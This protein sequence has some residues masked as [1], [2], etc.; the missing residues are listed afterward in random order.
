MFDVCISMMYVC[1]IRVTTTTVKIQNV[2]FTSVM[3]PFSTFQSW[4]NAPTPA[5]NYWFLSPQFTS[6]LVLECHSNSRYMVYPF[7]FLRSIST[8]PFWDSLMLLG[9]SLVPFYHQAEFQW[10]NVYHKLF[11]YWWTF[12]FFPLWSYYKY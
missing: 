12:G 4:L 9:I 2:F 8:S 7:L 11:F 6:L 10:M 3:F 1:I 5:S